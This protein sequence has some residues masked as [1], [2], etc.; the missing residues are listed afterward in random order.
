MKLIISD[1]ASDVA[2]AFVT[3]K[4]MQAIIDKLN[5]SG[6][7]IEYQEA[8]IFLNDDWEDERD[9]WFNDWDRD[10]HGAR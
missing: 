10:E 3:K 7:D 1:E 8:P 4:E 6:C 2:D 5:S 9:S